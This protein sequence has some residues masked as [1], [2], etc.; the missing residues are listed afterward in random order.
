MNCI[1]LL[2]KPVFGRSDKAPVNGGTVSR[3]SAVTRLVS[4]TKLLRR[5]K[6][7]PRRSKLF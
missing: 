5:P 6:T 4:R 2:I 3:G 7:E 1:N